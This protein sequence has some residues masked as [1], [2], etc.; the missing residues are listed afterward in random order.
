MS[1]I[2]KE[3]TKIMARRATQ[4]DTKLLLFAIQR[5]IGFETLCARRF[6]GTTLQTDKVIAIVKQ[7]TYITVYL[8]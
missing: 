4:I 3:L 2:R 1:S 6:T 5:T 7:I 8:S